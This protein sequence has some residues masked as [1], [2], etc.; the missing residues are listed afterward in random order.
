MSQKTGVAAE[1]FTT[2]N[3]YNTFDRLTSTTDNCGNTNRYA[4]DSRSNLTHS[5]DAKADGTLGCPGTVNAQGNSMRYTYDGINRRL[6]MI[7]DLRVGGVGSGPVDIS[8]PFNTDGQIIMR[9]TW[10]GNSRL[11]SLADDKE[12]LT[13][14]NY[15]SLNRL[16]VETFADGTTKTYIYDRDDNLERHKDNI[17]NIQICLYDAINRRT[18]CD[19]TRASGVIGTTLATYGYDGLSRMT[20]ITDNNDPADT[21]DDSTVTLA[22]DS[23]SRL[24]E[25]VQNGKVITGDWFANEQR[26]GLTYPDSRKL[27]LAFDKLDRIKTIRD[28]GAAV[29]IVNYDY[30]GPARVLERVHQNGTRLTYLNDAG[31]ADTGY[32]PIKRMVT[33]RH[34]RN[35]NSLVVGFTHAYDRED[36]KGFEEKLHS[37]SSSELYDYDS[38]YRITDFQRGQLTPAKDG[39]VGPPQKTQLWDLDGVGNWQVNTVNGAVENR[40]VNEINEYVT[41]NSTST[42]H[43]D[44]GNLIDDGILTFQWDYRNRLHTVTRKADGALIAVYSY[45]ALNR[46]IRKVVTNSGALNGTT[47][48]F[49]DNWRVLEERNGT[50]ALVQQY[51]FGMYLDEPLVLDRN[52]EGDSSAIGAGDQR[53]FYHQNTLYSIFALTDMSATVVESYQYDAYGTPSG[54]S[55]ASNPYMFTGQRLDP[56]TG[57]YYYKS[58]YFSV[59]LGRFLS[60]DPIGVWGDPTNLGNAYA[61]V[62]NN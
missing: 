30:I 5:S 44:N 14:Y 26:V 53:L 59:L 23:L 29:S 34:L 38:P 13:E 51:V 18:R 50:D 43:D 15:D 19:I 41:I 45:D 21:G 35:D 11:K 16:T 27:A 46:R 54:P 24:I 31:T 9:S 48:F 55:A 33:H 22:Y 37:P 2:I 32:D 57:V 61:Y 17:G 4:Y 12:N 7:Q 52:L 39:I 1:T 3:Q 42:P 25:E 58:R 47:D 8:N 36:N 40:T 56:E 49:Y 6:Q 10:D 62:G 20:R 28:S 60:R